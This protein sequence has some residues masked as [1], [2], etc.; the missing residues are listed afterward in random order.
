[1]RGHVVLAEADA[2]A[3]HQA[4]DQRRDPGVDVDDRAA[5]KVD[6]AL[7]EEI[8]VRVPDHVG[9]REVGEGAPEDR[10]GRTALNFTRSAK[11]PMI[12]AGVIAAKVIWKTM[13]RYSGIT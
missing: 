6:G 5:G 3:D 12:S 10:E 7:D 13:N 2:L 9:D 11:A 8:A 4:A 1:M